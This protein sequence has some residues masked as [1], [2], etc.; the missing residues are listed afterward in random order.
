MKHHLY[1]LLGMAMIAI[2][3]S[4]EKDMPDDPT[5]Q[6]IP[7]LLSGKW[8]YTDNES[9]DYY[10]C[11][12]I[13]F[14]STTGYWQISQQEYNDIGMCLG[15]MTYD[16]DTRTL[17][18]N[19]TSE[20]EHLK[21]N[22][23]QVN[24][25]E[26]INLTSDRLTAHIAD[27]TIEYKRNNE[28]LIIPKYVWTNGSDENLNPDGKVPSSYDNGIDLGLSVYW[29]EY[30][31]GSVEDIE[32]GGSYGW[33][34]ATGTYYTKDEMKYPSAN[35]PSDISGTKYDIASHKWGNG[36]RIP[37]KEEMEELVDNCYITWYNWCQCWEFTSIIN[38][39]SIKLP[40]APARNGKST[41]D[42]GCG[43]WT[44]TLDRTTMGAYALFASKSAGDFYDINHFKRSCGYQIRPVKDKN[45]DTD[46]HKILLGSWAV[47]T[48]DP[49]RKVTVQLKVNG[50]CEG[51]DWYDIDGDNTFSQKESTWKGT[52]SIAADEITISA[53]SVLAGSYTFTSVSS[54]YF[55]AADEDGFKI[56][57]TKE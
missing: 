4:S 35:P 54:N 41:F 27:K 51:T 50:V 36:W 13:S 22:G 9:E 39:N 8:I 3:C 42:D 40:Y 46:L 7:E 55:E 1:F 21:M 48:D 2:S 47:L 24:T 12:G 57:A 43:Y 49:S 10:F 16:A 5:K 53:E 38:G 45:S 14:S 11:Q 25:I 56:Y 44:S 26:I 15:T 30:N 18:L 33:G 19:C 32:T 28:S 23:V 52:Y 29:A 6:D 31:V 34:D 20:H 17:H 37:T